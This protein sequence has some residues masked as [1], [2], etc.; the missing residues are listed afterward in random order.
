MCIFQDYSNPFQYLYLTCNL[1][2][3]RG[4]AKNKTLFHVKILSFFNINLRKTQTRATVSLNCRKKISAF[5]LNQ[6]YADKIVNI[7]HKQSK[8]RS[9]HPTTYSF[10]VHSFPSWSDDLLFDCWWE[11]W[12]ILSANWLFRVIAVPMLLELAKC[13]KF[14]FVFSGILDTQGCG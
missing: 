5:A 13:W 11:M 8:R 14:S 12:S 9:W 4:L 1:K 6:H 10:R 2:F 7:F 3:S